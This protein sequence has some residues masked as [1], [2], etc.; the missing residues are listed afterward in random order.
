MV[1][2]PVQRLAGVVALTLAPV[3]TMAAVLPGVP[4]YQWYYGC[5]PTSGAMIVGYWDGL[6][7]Y[8]DLF[9]GDASVETQA[10]RDMI[11]S[12][13]HI[14]GSPHAQ[15]CVADFMGTGLN[16]TTAHSHIGPGLEAY[17]EWDDPNTPVNEAYEAERE[18]H[19][20]VLFG[21]D[22]TWDLLKS[23]IDAGRP[24]LLNLGIR[25]EGK[26]LGHTV[27]GYGYQAD[28]FEISLVGQDGPINLTVG[29]FAIR[30]TW[31]EGIEGATWCGWDGSVVH[32]IIDE[33]GV[34]WWPWVDMVGGPH[35]SYL[36]WYIYQ[37]IT[38]DITVPEPTTVALLAA[39]L[40]LLIMV[41]IRRG[42]P[43]RRGY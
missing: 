1:R 38:L 3:S 15:N 22:A 39:P 20:S 10:V 29:G 33:Y 24:M 31:A 32:P 30:D 27:V 34:E 9:Y 13:E 21:G 7:G 23:E 16:G 19:Q 40:P 2:Q 37:G 26:L 8:G 43:R 18:L 36:E 42:R 17:I 28:M 35:A 6:P 12:P 14:S 4:S 25:Y 41:Q 11:A 5:S